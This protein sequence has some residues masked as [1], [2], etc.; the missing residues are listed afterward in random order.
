[1]RVRRA[2]LSV[3]DKV[4]IVELA[5]GL[6][7]CGVSLL[8]TG[9]TFGRLADAGVEV[10]AV[11]EYTGSPEVMGGR[12]KT[13]H[14]KVHGAI[15]ARA[16]ADDGDLRR[17]NAKPIDLVVVNLYPFEQTLARGSATFEELIETIDI[18]GPCMLRASAKN[19]ARVTAVCDPADYGDVLSALE[20][21]GAIPEHLRKSLAAKAFEHTAH[22]DRQ[23]ADWLASELR[24]GA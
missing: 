7:R 5:R 20:A 18:G 3:S 8:S 9:G 24:S 19:H 11:E 16:E 4:G 2:L 1:M 22:Y 17:L 10:Q 6:E 21:R 14:P 13:L 15:L 12:V 23:I